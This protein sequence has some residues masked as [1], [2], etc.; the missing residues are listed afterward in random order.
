MNLI[1]VK[2]AK[3]IKEFLRLPVELYKG[4]SHWIRPLDK[5]VEAVFDPK[6]NE[7]FSHGDCTRWILI[8]DG[9]TVGRISAFVNE[10]T[11]SQSTST[12]HDL[13]VGGCGFFECIN[14]QEVADL[15]FNKAKD[16]LI[17]KGCNAFDGPINF[18]ERLSFWGLLIEG[19]EYDPNFNMPYTHAYYQDLFEKFG[20]ELYFKQLTFGRKVMDPLHPAYK[21]VSDRLFAD[22]ELTFTNLDLKHLDKFTEDFRYIYNKAWAGH[23]GVKEMS[24]E[25]A[26]SQFKE[27]KQIVDPRIVIFAYHKEDPIAFY[28]NIP[29][30]NQVLK[31]VNSPKLDLISKLKFA[32]HL[33]W[34]KTTNKAIGLVFGV[35]PEYQRRGIMIGLVEFMRIQVQDVIKGRYTDYEMNWIGD[36][37]PKMVKISEGIG[38]VR[39]VHYTYRYLIDKSIPFERCKD[40]L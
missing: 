10:N 13:R 37:N 8:K 29:E 9:K 35:I 28:V 23:E 18:G 26:Q 6:T 19:R 39:K 7:F 1:E 36:F 34:G 12:D 24:L 20:F 5:D 17:A 14:D 30:L 33:K 25:Q 11:A 38:S 16:W 3:D 31:K 4:E 21:R 2:S 15:L 27:L 22:P 32:W 40:I